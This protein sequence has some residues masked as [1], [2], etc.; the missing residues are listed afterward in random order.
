M[1]LYSSRHCMECVEQK[2]SAD[3]IKTETARRDCKIPG[4]ENV[5]GR[6]QSRADQ[7]AQRNRA[8]HREIHKETRRRDTQTDKETLSLPVETAPTE[9]NR[10]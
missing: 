9:P 1:I 4:K 3:N 10:R 8:Q 6:R 5:S 2:K 7:E